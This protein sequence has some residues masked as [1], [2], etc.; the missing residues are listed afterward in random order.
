[1][2]YVFVMFA[3]DVPVLRTHSEAMAPL[4]SAAAL[5]ISS[6]EKNSMG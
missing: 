6:E 2:E 5:A 3:I 4:V 1:M